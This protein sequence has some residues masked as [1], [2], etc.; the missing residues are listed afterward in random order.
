MGIIATENDARTIGGSSAS[1]TS[2]LCATKARAIALSCT[3]SG[4]YDNNQLV[5]LSDL[6]SHKN[7]LKFT[8]TSSG[9]FTFTGNNLDYSTNGG[10][11]WATLSSGS[12][13]PSFSSGT[14]V[15]WKFTKADDGNS[16]GTFSSTCSFTASGN[17]MSLLYGDNFENQTA[18]MNKCFQSLFNNC[19][20][21]TNAQSL[22][23]P[24]VTL[25][26]NCYY[27]MFYNCTSLTVAPQLPAK[28][29]VDYCY[30]NMFYGCTSLTSASNLPATTLAKGCYEYMFC[31][32]TS[33]TTPPQLPALNLQT[34]CYYGMFQYCSALTSVPSLPASVLT[35]YCYSYMFN[36]CT[37]LTTVS[38]NLLA[39]TALASSCYSDMFDNCTSLR[40]AP[41][42]PAST[43]VDCCY[44]YMFHGCTSLVNPP[45]ISATTLASQCCSNMFQNC[46]SLIS[47]PTLNAQT[48]VDRCYQLMFYGCSLLNNITCYAAN[49]SAY[50]CTSNWV[51]GVAATGTFVQASGVSWSRGISGIP[52]GWVVSE[53]SIGSGTCTIEN[54]GIFLSDFDYN[55]NILS[56]TFQ[57]TIKVVATPESDSVA[58]S[59]RYNPT[60]IAQYNAGTSY[61]LTWSSSESHY[62]LRPYA[63]LN[64]NAPWVEDGHNTDIHIVI[65]TNVDQTGSLCYLNNGLTL[66]FDNTVIPYQASYFKM[67]GV[68]PVVLNEET[69]CCLSSSGNGNQSTYIPY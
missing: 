32:C 35:A 21:L 66:T 19:S 5:Q 26:T 12:A 62:A 60:I 8:T 25:A 28:I 50:Y 49:I 1:Y 54:Y 16:L 9:T 20:G 17:A 6:S 45:V 40:S 52:S 58:Q 47:S 59:G 67:N 63:P 13:T 68:Y 27:N 22:Q 42:L 18:V 51:S 37:S 43:L 64:F 48:L 55:S 10:D 46:T 65:E 44:A 41:N 11:S 39:G 29:L 30:S 38:S 56:V 2:N 33:L 53:P 69:P 4:N 23:L 15:V 31:G 57:Y 24:A 3:V 34:S 14:E 61:P 7:Y 36:G